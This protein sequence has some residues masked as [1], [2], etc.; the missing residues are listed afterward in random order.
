MNSKCPGNKVIW[1]KVIDT[2]TARYTIY[3]WDTG[4]YTIEYRVWGYND[5]DGLDLFRV[6]DD[7]DYEVW[8]KKAVE[9]YFGITIE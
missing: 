4:A 1:H 8:A 6:E 2:G 5:E 7:D 3:K 9:E